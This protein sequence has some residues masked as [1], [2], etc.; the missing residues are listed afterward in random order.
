MS[1][2][3]AGNDK[4]KLLEALWTHAKPAAFFTM[5]G[6][7]G[8]AFDEAEAEKALKGYIDYFCGRCIKTNLSGTTAD[9]SAYDA[10]WGAGSFAKIVKDL[11]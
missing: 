1:V 4:K 9:P 7:P 11:S 6:L 8:P 10:E 3:I 2:S 5:R